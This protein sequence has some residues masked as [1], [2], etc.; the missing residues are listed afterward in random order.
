MMM[1]LDFIKMETPHLKLVLEFKSKDW[2]S[3]G[4]M[5]ETEYYCNRDEEDIPEDE[6]DEEG[7]YCNNERSILSRKLFEK[8]KA[9]NPSDKLSYILYKLMRIHDKS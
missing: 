8:A 6:R 1:Y 5:K 7:G 4:A 2:I 9:K 3:Y